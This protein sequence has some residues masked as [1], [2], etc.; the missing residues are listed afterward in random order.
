MSESHSV[1]STPRS[2]TDSRAFSS[3]YPPSNL[4]STSDSDYLPCNL[5]TSSNYPSCN[6]PTGSDY[7]PCNLGSVSDTDSDTGD[8]T[9]LYEGSLSLDIFSKNPTIFPQRTPVTDTDEFDELPGRVMVTVPGS[10]GKKICERLPYITS[11]FAQSWA[12]F[13]FSFSYCLITGRYIW[14]NRSWEYESEE[15]MIEA[16][17][18]GESDQFCRHDGHSWWFFRASDNTW[19][20]IN[21]ETRCEEVGKPKNPSDWGFSN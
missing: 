5:P 9:R 1:D 6:L 2:A 12:E 3:D 7:P 10:D 18:L 11:P 17:S 16:I 4:G 8:L 19:W 14:L 13:L 20:R 21:E 15:E